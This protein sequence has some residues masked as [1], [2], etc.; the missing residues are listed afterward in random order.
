MA[1]R[2]RQHEEEYVREQGL[3]PLKVE[4]LIKGMR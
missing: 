3:L 4:T 2:V 1:A